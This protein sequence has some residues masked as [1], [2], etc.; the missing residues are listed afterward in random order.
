[1]KKIHFADSGISIILSISVALAVR[2]AQQPTSV[3]ATEMHLTIFRSR[4]SERC[5]GRDQKRC[6]LLDILGQLLI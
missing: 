3:P 6:I 5:H 2:E 4:E 1:M